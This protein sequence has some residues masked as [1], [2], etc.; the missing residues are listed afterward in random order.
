MAEVSIN[1]A[2]RTEFGK[3]AS[4]RDRRAGLVPAVIYGHG[5]EPRHIALPARELSLALKQP[6][7]LLDITIDGK[8][9]LTLP[10]SVVKNPLTQTFEHLDLIIVNRGE[11][12]VVEIPVHTTGE[13][14]RDGILEHILTHISVEVEATNIPSFVELDLTGLA[15]G[16]SKYAKDVAL[17]AG[18]KLISDADAAVAHL[19]TKGGPAAEEA[20][21]AAAATEAAN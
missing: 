14:D 7:V 21:P 3:G 8:T 17:P 20:A 12:V 10:K 15:A 6:N 19:S 11:R 9:E 18:A 1:G 13:H 2:K 16:S 5:S 4:R